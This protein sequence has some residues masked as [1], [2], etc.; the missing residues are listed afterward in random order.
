MQ[1]SFHNLVRNTGYVNGYHIEHILAH[2]EENLTLFTNDEEVFE[3]ERNRLGGLLLL[4]GNANLSSSNETYSN[5]LRTYVQTLY[6]NATLHPDTYHSNLDLIQLKSKFNL[7][8]R[9]METFGPEE[10]EERHRLLADFI[11]IIWS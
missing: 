9:P 5:K 3:R 1:Q 11:K 8:L 4:R 10:L 2:N 7:N 6:W